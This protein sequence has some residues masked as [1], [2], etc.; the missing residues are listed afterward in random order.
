MYTIVAMGY[1]LSAS[2]MHKLLDQTV[3]F[4]IWGYGNEH[5]E[6]KYVVALGGTGIAGSVGR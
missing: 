5:F 4:L 2:F 3:S 6:T 1:A